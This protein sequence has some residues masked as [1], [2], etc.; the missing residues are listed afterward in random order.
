MQRAMIDARKKWQEENYDAFRDI[1]RA[2]EA[3]GL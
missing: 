2:I 1:E 3:L